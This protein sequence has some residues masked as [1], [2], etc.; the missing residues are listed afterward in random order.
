MVPVCIFF[1]LWLGNLFLQEKLLGL[2]ER[3]YLPGFSYLKEENEKS[4]EDWLLE[5]AIRL[6]P[7]LAFTSEKQ[8][9]AGEVED[10]QTIARILKEQAEDETFAEAEEKREADPT[11]SSGE[12]APTDGGFSM[13]KLQDFEYLL[14]RFYTVDS[15]TM[16]GPEQLNIQDLMSRSSKIDR[17]VQGPKIL[18]FHTHSQETFADSVPGDPNTSIVGIGEYLTEL[19]NQKGI[20]TLHHT[21]VYD[22]VD[23][24]LDRSNAYELVEPQVRK[25]LK[26]NPSIQ[27]AI[28]LHRD[29]VADTT[30]LVTE[31][32]GKPTAKI[33]FFNGLSRTR[34]NGDIAY[35][36][37]PYIQENLS[38]S[39]QMQLACETRYPGYA[40]HIYLKGYRYS[41]HM[42]PKSLLIEA[43]AQ[44][45]T[46]GEMKNS[47][48]ILAN[49]L[50]GVVTE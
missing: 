11:Q 16:I 50:Y 45:N 27:V 15:I 24:K 9:Y 17:S 35:L 1:I 33:M 34:T 4:G 2:A 44:T 20:E 39:F 37:N 26:E 49:V 13:E 36:A 25:I 5:Q 38:F 23:G 42:L 29:G 48:E 12:N 6:L 43:G 32:A 8:A 14:N 7:Y 40:R 46:V 21:G 3:L 10:P 47:M 31:I 22:L 28:D 30:H 18:I 19:L 41:L